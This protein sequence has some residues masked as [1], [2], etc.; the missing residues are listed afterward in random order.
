MK[1]VIIFRVISAIA[2]L[3]V[4]HRSS[5]QEVVT[6]IVVDSASLAA[7]SSVNVQIK[8][9][10]SGTMTDEHGNFSIAAKRS[11]TL[12]FT[13]VGYQSLELPLMTYEAGVIRLSERYTLLEAVTIDEFRQRDLYEGMFDEQ[14]AQRRRSIPFYFSKAKKE[15]IKVQILKDEN[16]RVS[17]Y[18]EVVVNN[19]EFK[20]GLMKKHAL[21]EKE[22]YDILTSFNERHYQVMYYLTRA[23]LISMLNTFFDNRASLR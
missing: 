23:E 14:N 20:A 19:P 22:Y 11:D 1:S 6:G 18:V 17:T 9:G 13:L 3:L 12:I 16:L 8:N 2:L 5:G 21:T 10:S 4:A 15:K 7:L